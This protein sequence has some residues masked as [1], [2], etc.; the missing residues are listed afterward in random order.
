MEVLTAI[1]TSPIKYTIAKVAGHADYEES[2]DYEADPHCT[3]RNIDMDEQARLFQRN[4]PN[5]LTPS[6]T[7]MFY[8]S[9][10]IGLRILG[11]LI[12]GDIAN[13]ITLYSHGHPM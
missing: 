12:V 3:R 2:L 13:Q 6:T 4:H 9:Q 10:L 5:H 8:P 11:N 7:P 1:Q